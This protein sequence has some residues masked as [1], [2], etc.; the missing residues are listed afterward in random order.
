MATA[1]AAAKTARAAAN[2]RNSSFSPLPGGG[3]TR[4]RW[5]PPGPAA[6]DGRAAILEERRPRISATCA[7][8]GGR[9]SGRRHVTVSMAPARGEA[10]AGARRPARPGW[11]GLPSRV[12]GPARDSREWRLGLARRRSGSRVP[13]RT[14]GKADSDSRAERDLRG[15]SLGRV[16]LRTSRVSGTRRPMSCRK[17]CLSHFLGPAAAEERSWVKYGLKLAPRAVPSPSELGQKLSFALAGRQRTP[18][19]S[20]RQV[21]GLIQADQLYPRS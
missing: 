21:A 4:L 18:F 8:I 3:F 6:R 9:R 16:A 7:P 15:P 11:G 13:R 5:L 19:E 14:P 1:V 10:G 2:C 20:V 12:S 17:T